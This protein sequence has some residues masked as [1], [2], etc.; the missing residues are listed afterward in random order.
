MIF[1][2]KSPFIAD[3]PLG[4]WWIFFGSHRSSKGHTT[5]WW[6]GTCF[7]CFIFQYIGNWES[8]SQLTFILFRGFFQPPTRYL[9]RNIPYFQQAM[10]L[11]IVTMTSVAWLSTRADR[12]NSIWYCQGN[13]GVFEYRSRIY[14]SDITIYIY[15]Y[16]NTYYDYKYIHT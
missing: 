11:A 1:L 2:L 4:P 8:S 10:W 14:N 6:F 12:E 5:G 3:F 9:P 7:I 15:T 16:T 13:Y